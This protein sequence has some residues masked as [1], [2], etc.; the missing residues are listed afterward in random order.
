MWGV[1]FLPNLLKSLARTPQKRMHSRRV[2]ESELHASS[3]LQHFGSPPYTLHPQTHTFARKELPLQVSNIISRL[4]TPRNYLKSLKVRTS[5][6]GLM[7]S[8]RS[9]VGRLECTVSSYGG[10]P[11]DGQKPTCV[12][13]WLPLSLRQPLFRVNHQIDFGCLYCLILYCTNGGEL[14]Q[15]RCCACWAPYPA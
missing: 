12:R 13:S 6:F 9:G 11:D 15:W 8:L 7:V 10:G 2:S 14:A 4:Y 5:G 3:V 1:T